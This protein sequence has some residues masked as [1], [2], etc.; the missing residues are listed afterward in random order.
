MSQADFGIA[1]MLFLLV[2]GFALY[3]LCWPLRRERL[4]TERYRL[5]AVRDRLVRLAAD[6]QVQEED[7]LFQFLYQGVNRIIPR[8]ELLKL[9]TLVEALNS[10]TFK[11]F[12]ESH[13]FEKIMTSI[14]QSEPPVRETASQ[15]FTTIAEILIARSLFVRILVMSRLAV[16]STSL[17]SHA[18]RWWLRRAL[19]P[20]FKLEYLAYDYYRS[21]EKA[22]R[23]LAVAA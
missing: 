10:S 19:A 5:F 6:G 7:E 17:A 23:E 22:R 18:L 1:L 20:L 8:T 15:L 11:E 13:E 4:K 3:C 16:L 2:L 14:L 12:R 21:V 9:S